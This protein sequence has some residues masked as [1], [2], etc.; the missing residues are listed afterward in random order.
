MPHARLRRSFV[1]VTLLVAA[2][3]A[4]SAGGGGGGG[5]AT[6]ARFNDR[7]VSRELAEAQRLIE[8]K[9]WSRAI[10]QLKAAER[11]D[12]WSA[13]VHN[14]LGYSLRKS[15]ELDA[16]FRSYR[17]ALELDPQHK[18]AHEYI[19]EAYLMAN[20]P[21][22]AREHLDKL[23][24]LCGGENCEQYQDLAKAIADWQPPAAPK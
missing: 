1:P 15:G 23:K 11:K 7:D 12:R 21:D 20:Q 24:L 3:T 10:R 22:K 6:S 2:S 8:A 5:G 17:T 16:A 4:W 19:G 13:E 18:G 9:D 14:L